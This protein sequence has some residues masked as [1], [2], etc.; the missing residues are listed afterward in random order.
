MI[1]L[2]HY[3][4]YMSSTDFIQELVN[5]LNDKRVNYTY[6]ENLT[7]YDGYEDILVIY[8]NNIQ[9]KF[10]QYLNQ[11]HQ[12]LNFTLLHNNQTIYD[13]NNIIDYLQQNL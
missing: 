13:Y 2:N 1:N 6:D 7:F 9:Y 12:Y 5:W 8:I 3:Y 10:Y 4:I 11:N